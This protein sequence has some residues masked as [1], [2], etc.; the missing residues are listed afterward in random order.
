[1]HRGTHEPDT[2]LDD[3]HFMFFGV[4]YAD[5]A[6]RVHFNAWPEG[7]PRTTLNPNVA[8]LGTGIQPHVVRFHAVLG[9]WRD[10]N[11]DRYVGHAELGLLEYHPSAAGFANRCAASDPNGAG[12]YPHNDGTWVRELI[13][14]G[15][16]STALGEPRRNPTNE[17]LDG[18]LVWGD[19]GQPGDA[20]E[21]R[22]RAPPA[23]AGALAA[24]A[25]GATPSG[26]KLEPDMRFRFYAGTRDAGGLAHCE[27]TPGGTRATAHPAL[28]Y[29]PP[30]DAGA[31]VWRGSNGPSWSSDELWLAQRTIDPARFN[32]E[33]A[34]WATFYASLPGSAWGWALPG[35]LA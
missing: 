23:P 25:P 8:L 16:A 29:C 28:G 9:V 21:Q 1:M 11:D 20:P 22:C 2:A 17:Y 5:A 18:V 32:V 3:R 10:C 13:W 7:A 33:P 31:S 4:D 12:T 14:L 30:A 26:P 34:Q 24:C 35:R 15:P 6:P 19:W 27:R